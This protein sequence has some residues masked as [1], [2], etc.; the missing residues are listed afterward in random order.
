MKNGKKD[1]EGGVGEREEESHGKESEKSA[2]SVSV[3]LEAVLTCFEPFFSA[4]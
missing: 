4:F 3:H 2:A 1:T